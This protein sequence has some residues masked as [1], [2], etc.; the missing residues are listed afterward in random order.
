MED[1]D[2]NSAAAD[3]LKNAQA[4]MDRANSMI[5]ETL[6]H[7]PVKK[8][9]TK[10]NGIETTAGLTKHSHIILEFNC[11]ED[12]EKFFDSINKP[13]PRFWQK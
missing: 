8:K 11:P 1:K 10:M 3:M 2:Y 5:K 9:R 13:K 4:A 6:G 7:V 12:A